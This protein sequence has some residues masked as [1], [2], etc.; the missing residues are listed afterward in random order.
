MEDIFNLFTTSSNFLYV[1]YSNVTQYI[2]WS[3]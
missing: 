2:K 3:Y 1:Y